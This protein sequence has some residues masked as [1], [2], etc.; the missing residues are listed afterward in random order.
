MDK[1]TQQQHQ[2]QQRKQNTKN[3]IPRAVDNFP[4]DRPKI[5]IKGRAYC[6]VAHAT[7]N[8]HFTSTTCLE[9]TSCMRTHFVP[10]QTTRLS[11]VGASGAYLPPTKLLSAK[12]HGNL[13][14][15]TDV[16]DLACVCEYNEGHLWLFL[17]DRYN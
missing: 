6:F 14:G 5:L 1:E 4:V 17:P 15:Y 13:Y 9:S 8:K 12:P 7:S 16:V 3:K 11:G 2:K 10:G